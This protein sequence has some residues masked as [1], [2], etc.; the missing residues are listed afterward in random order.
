MTN[1]QIL[2]D[3]KKLR[4]L[5]LKYSPILYFLM[6]QVTIKVTERIPVAAAYKNVI[7][8]NPKTF[9]DYSEEER[10]FFLAHE[11]MHILLKHSY[12]MKEISEDLLPY[13]NIAADFI[14][15]N[16]L[17]QDYKF[18][19]PNFVILELPIKA[20]YRKDSAEEIALKLKESNNK[21]IEELVNKF[22]ESLKDIFKDLDDI[23]ENGKT[24]FKLYDDKKDIL[25]ETD[26]DKIIIQSIK[27]VGDNDPL[28]KRLAELLSTKIDWKQILRNFV[29]NRIQKG[30]MTTYSRRN[31]RVQN[32]PG[33]SS[34]YELKIWVFVDVSASISENEYSQ[35]ITEVHNL[36]KLHG[37]NLV[38]VF[39]DKK[40]EGVL[41]NPKLDDLLQ[42]KVTGYGGT[43]FKPCYETVKK[44]IKKQDIVILFSDFVFG[45]Q[46]YD[47]IDKIANRNWMLVTTADVLDYFIPKG[48]WI[49]LAA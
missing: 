43:E 37:V 32:L 13:H 8:I 48:R 14:I 39:W 2:N 3:I 10:V 34:I 31:R 6:N 46:D 16:Y 9:L 15:N 21:T 22:R 11:L 41:E 24:I 7:L 35:F 29:S 1:E 27:G 19:V 17:K 12:R 28:G 23:V 4:L 25:P 30:I 26:I 44:D 38:V 49:K 45:Q 20:D 18:K 42:V 33:I 36:S 47:F 40:V 5:L